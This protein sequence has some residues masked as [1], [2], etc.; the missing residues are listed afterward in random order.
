M[1]AR[2][3]LR[4]PKTLGSYVNFD[5]RSSRSICFGG[6]ELEG[7]FVVFFL[8]VAFLPGEAYCSE[9]YNACYGGARGYCSSVLA[10]PG[11]FDFEATE[12]CGVAQT[13]RVSG[14][15]YRVGSKDGCPCCRYRV[16]CRVDACCE[17]GCYK[18]LNGAVWFDKLER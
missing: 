13:R 16:D 18:N 14:H 10:E 11:R 7:L 5:S 17:L 15:G 2:I 8:Q 6:S 4:T 12:G 9:S 1:A 3:S